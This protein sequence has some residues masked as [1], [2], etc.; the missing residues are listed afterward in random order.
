VNQEF[1]SSHW[2]GLESSL[3][4]ENSINPITS[5]QLAMLMEESL[6][7]QSFHAL[8]KSFTIQR[9]EV[10]AFGIILKP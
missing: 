8:Y 6:D 9:K 10:T 4:S 5:I 1:I 3:F 7:N 2:I